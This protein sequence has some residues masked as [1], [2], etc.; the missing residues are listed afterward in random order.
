MI[1]FRAACLVLIVCS[2]GAGRLWSANSSHTRSSP[3]SDRVRALLRTQADRNSLRELTTG[4]HLLQGATE[5]TRM[6]AIPHLD[7]SFGAGRSEAA[8]L[9][10]YGY[11]S[12]LLRPRSLDTALTWYR[13]GAI[14]GN[15]VGMAAL[16]ASMQSVR[17]AELAESYKYS[18]AVS[19]IKPDRSLLTWIQDQAQSGSPR[20]QYL[21]ARLLEMGF[22]DYEDAHVR[23][24][25]LYTDAASGGHADAPFKLWLDYK[26]HCYDEGLEVIKRVLKEN[27]YEKEAEQRQG[28]FWL[29][30]HRPTKLIPVT[31]PD[32][33][34]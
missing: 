1:L 7:A 22:L 18:R 19:G 21:L 8:V 9:L 28:K 5:E 15:L 11:E 27:R 20:H 16:E 31:F 2:V 24:T 14:A 10:G 34:W 3:S 32:S 13:K 17:D 26:E 23:A 12:G 33:G 30:W 4:R 29:L 6:Q 25:Q